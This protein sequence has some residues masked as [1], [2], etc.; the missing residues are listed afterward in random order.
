MGDQVLYCPNSEMAMDYHLRTEPNVLF[1]GGRGSGKSV[2]GRW[3]AHMKALA[4]P[5]FKYCILR[6]TYPELLKSHL[7]D[8]PKEMRFFG[9]DF[10]IGTKVARYP[11]G[12]LGFF[13]H[14][15]TEQDVLNLLSAE[16]Y[17]MFFDE[18]ST[19]DWEMFVKLAASC[20]IPTKFKE[21]MG[22]TADGYVRAA[23]NP[24]GV[25][26]EM[27]NRYWVTKDVDLE[28][29]P[30]YN[31]NDWY[32]IKANLEDNPYLSESYLA[33]FSGMSTNVRKAWVEGEFSMENALFDFHPVLDGKPY[34]VTNEIDLPKI[35]K[36]ATIYRRTSS[37]AARPAF[38]ASSAGL[39]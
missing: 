39:P 19:F 36:S 26:A 5:G 6:R 8:V 21:L 31:P 11:N 7:I 1:Y 18:V 16:F 35:L 27:I 4:F 12:S 24:L 23:T 3:D 13:S 28:E 32:S 29:D 38:P 17:L 22:T 10:N 20:R 9:G 33:R 14:C 2:T 34:H 37:N 15:N 25:S 30:H